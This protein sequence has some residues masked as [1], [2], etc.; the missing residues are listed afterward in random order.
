MLA[1]CKALDTD[2]VNGGFRCFSG[3]GW[4]MGAKTMG[5]QGDGG[6]QPHTL[7][8]EGSLYSLT[9]DEVESHLGSL[10]K[11][12]GSMNLD[13]LLKT[14]WS[15]EAGQGTGLSVGMQPGQLSSSSSVHWLP[16]LSRDLSSKTVDEVWR[17]IQHRRRKPDQERQRTLGE[18]TLEDFLAKAGIVNGPDGESCDDLFGD[19]QRGE[20]N[21][22]PCWAQYQLSLV[23]QTQACQ[24]Q[25]Q[26][27]AQSFSGFMAGHS[28]ELL[29]QPMI[30]VAAYPETQLAVAAVS[31]ARGTLSDTQ[32][33]GRKRVAPGEVVEKTVERRQK[34]MIK[35]R[36]SAARSRARKQAYTNELENKISY[37]EEEIERLKKQQAAEK[38]V[39]CAPPPDPKPQLRRTSSGPL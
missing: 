2:F 22:Q 32:T 30:D 24:Q 29:Q 6:V 36:E 20:L 23:E 39:Q 7:T 14:V 16:N 11:P 19:E 27:L 21:L 12:L 13:E 37:L 33:L 15:A 25:R 35:N 5:S 1:Y 28:H 31:P 18:M 38:E 26:Q 9:L 4:W 3:V 34:R 10:D 17:S 8:R